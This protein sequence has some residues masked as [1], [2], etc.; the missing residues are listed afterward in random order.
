MFTAFAA[1]LFSNLTF[2]ENKNEYDKNLI[3]KS[4]ELIKESYAVIIGTDCYDV[5]VAAYNA[6]ISLGH[7]AEVAHTRATRTLNACLDANKP[8]QDVNP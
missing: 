8:V 5:F 6:W 7:S 1:L 3:S 2:A 4:N